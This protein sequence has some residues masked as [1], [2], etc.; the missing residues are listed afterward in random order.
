MQ[1]IGTIAGEAIDSRAQRR[2]FRQNLLDT[3]AGH[4]Q[5]AQQSLAQLRGAS[6]PW[7]IVGVGGS[8]AVLGVMAVVVLK[9]K[10]EPQ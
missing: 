10:G 4:A 1:L 6:F 2:A 5:A 9:K 8:V 7:W 3:R